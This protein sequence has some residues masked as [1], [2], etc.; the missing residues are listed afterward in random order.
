MEKFYLN[1]IK[2]YPVL[3]KIAH[4]IYGVFPLTLQGT[5]TILISATCLKVF[6]YGSMDLVVFSL[7]ICA[8][9]ILMFCLFCVIIGGLIIQRRIQKKFSTEASNYDSISVEVGFPNETGLIIPP[10]KLLPLVQLSWKI[11]YP[12]HIR[13]R[14]RTLSKN[15]LAEEIIPKSRCKAQRVTREFIIS[16]VFGFC[17]YSWTENQAQNFKAL[18]QTNTLNTIPLLQS[19]N[20]E[21]GLPN[22]SGEPEGDRMEIRRYAPGDSIRSVMW[23]AYARTRKLNVRLAEKSVSQNTKTVAY[24]LSS[25]QDE[26]AAA[27]ARMALEAGALGED[28]TFGADGTQELCKDLSGALDAIAKS[29]AIGAPHEYG[30]DKFLKLAA[31]QL[32]AHCIVFA[33]AE[34]AS[35]LPKLTKT[36]HSL[37]SGFSAVLA[38]DGFEEQQEQKLWKKLLFRSLPDSNKET[39]KGS[40]KSDILRLLTQLS[41]L[42]ESVVLIDRRTG[43]SFDKQFRKV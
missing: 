33:S 16:D 39:G 30:L 24:L 35:W 28:W 12:D 18:P 7:A 17:R 43:H 14:V 22:P 36:V 26:A 37:S 27:V 34:T 15:A 1:T 6:G 8:I 40:S 38:I 42:V 11:V 31:G 4:I 23:K 5:I 25:K 2:N 21:D 10:I 41:Q 32:G 19:L 3:K 20:A 29:R 9:A 13:T